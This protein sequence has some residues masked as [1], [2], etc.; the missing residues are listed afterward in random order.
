MV[1][2]T[3]FYQQ[4]I[5]SN[6]RYRRHFTF[7]LETICSALNYVRCIMV[8]EKSIHRIDRRLILRKNL[9]GRLIANNTIQHFRTLFTQLDKRFRFPRN[10]EI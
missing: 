10:L 5:A 2:R 6:I 8:G 9:F 7:G 3:F 4:S 1:K